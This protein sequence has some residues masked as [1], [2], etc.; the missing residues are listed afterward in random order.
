M[1]KKFCCISFL[2][3]PYWIKLILENK[4]DLK[5]SKTELT[6]LFRFATSQVH[7]SFDGKIFDQ[8]HRLAISSPLEPALANMFMGHNEQ[9]D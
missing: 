5:Y 3:K 1:L 8:V 6:V 9:N 7:F 4:K 2:F